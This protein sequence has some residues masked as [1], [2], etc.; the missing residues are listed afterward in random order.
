MWFFR[1]SFQRGCR[2]SQNSSAAW[3]WRDTDAKR[4][5]NVQT[6]WESGT[7]CHNIQSTRIEARPIHTATHGNAN[8]WCQARLL[9]IQVFYSHYLWVIVTPY[10]S[11]A[12]CATFSPYWLP[13]FFMFLSTY[14]TSRTIVS[15]ELGEQL[16]PR[17]LMPILIS[18]MR[19]ASVAMTEAQE[20]RD[21]SFE[22]S[23][24]G[25]IVEMNDNVVSSCLCSC[26]CSCS[27]SCLCSCSCSCSC[28]CSCSSSWMQYT[29]TAAP[30]SPECS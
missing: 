15:A 26:S 10:Y 4:I 23:P 14:R 3:C 2:R 13:S 18:S 22:G 21:Y 27:C 30:R 29:S 8:D 17:Q 20:L 1:L 6:A 9:H 24:I 19:T 5:R 28:L 12:S 11:T 16:P 7:W 25:L